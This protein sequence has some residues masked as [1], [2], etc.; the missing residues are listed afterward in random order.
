M[1]D[2]PNPNLHRGDG[3][4]ARGLLIALA[5]IVAIVALLAIAG[6]IGGGGTGDGG[7][8]APTQDA[9]TPAVPSTAVPT[10]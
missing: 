5:I 2:Y 4:S 7:E 8:G 1:S 3:V 6:A 9:I 10:E